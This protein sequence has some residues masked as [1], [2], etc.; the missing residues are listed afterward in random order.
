MPGCL[1]TRACLT[2]QK[3]GGL[4]FRGRRVSGAACVMTFASRFVPRSGTAE[5]GGLRRKQN[6][7]WHTRRGSAGCPT[8]WS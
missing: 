2:D 7:Q 5:P 1:S 3:G 6:Y 4:P 8:A